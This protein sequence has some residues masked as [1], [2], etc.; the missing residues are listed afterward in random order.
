[1]LNLVPGMECM[2]ATA[3]KLDELSDRMDDF[4]LQR[5]LPLITYDTVDN[6]VLSKVHPLFAARGNVWLA[7]ILGQDHPI[8]EQ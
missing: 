7:W 3:E 1:M 4:E 8:F 2:A 6:Y 5:H